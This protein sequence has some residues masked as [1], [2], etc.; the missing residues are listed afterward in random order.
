MSQ[1]LN[2]TDKHDIYDVLN[3][4][5][6]AG[7]SKTVVKVIDHNTGEVLYEG[8]NR[9]LVPG[10]QMAACKQFGLDPVVEL[11]TYNSVLKLENSYEDY[12]KEPLN[13]PITCLWCVGRSGYLNGPGEVLVPANTDRMEPKNDL[14]PFRYVDRDHDLDI[15][16]RNVY[17]GRQINEVTG[18][19]SYYFKAFDT[20]PQLH[21]RYLDGTEVTPLMYSI[22]S[23]QQVEVYVEM[24]LAVNRLDFRSYF[25]KVLG[26][27]RATISSISLLTG[28]WDRHICENPDAEEADRIYYRWYQDVLPFTKYNFK[29]EELTDLDR[30]IDFNYQVFY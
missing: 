28:W 13:E 5:M 22:D 2:L 11:P 1:V 16:Q 29:E 23:S 8:S 21:V 24:R 14:L 6:S 25:D 15:D 10:S 12:S 17:F 30:A 19:I 3:H 9:I 7:P 18:M 4:R 20:L 26:W 27:D